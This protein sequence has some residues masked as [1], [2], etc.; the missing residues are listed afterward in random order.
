MPEEKKKPK[1][2][3]TITLTIGERGTVLSV[4]FEGVSAPFAAG[5]RTKNWINIVKAEAKKV[6]AQAKH[7][8]IK[9]DAKKKLLAKKKELVSPTK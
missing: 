4:K 3:G 5:G 6:M 9:A 1:P 2:G 8:R 7:E